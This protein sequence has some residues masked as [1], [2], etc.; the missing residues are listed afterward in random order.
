[1]GLDVKRRNA[2]RPV[3]KVPV[4][5]Y[6]DAHF[7][8][9]RVIRGGEGVEVVRG[10]FCGAV[11]S[12]EMVVEE[13]ADFGD[14]EVARDDEGAEEVVGGVCTELGHGS[15]STSVVRQY[16]YQ[17]SDKGTYVKITGFPKFL[18]MKLTAEQVYAKLSVP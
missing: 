4:D 17:P 12:E 18:N 10:D 3:Y 16:H 11:A 1:M 14:H 7:A 2:V 9:R 13:E 15:L 6:R 8:E 5:L